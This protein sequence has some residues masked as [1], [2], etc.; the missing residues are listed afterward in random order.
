MS[1]VYVT[2]LNILNINEP[3][4]SDAII[5]NILLLLDE[6]ESNVIQDNI[7]NNLCEYL[8]TKNFQY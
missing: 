6:Y 4:L 3:L 8:E 5:F 2:I 7:F 1:E